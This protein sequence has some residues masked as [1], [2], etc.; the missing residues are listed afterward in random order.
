MQAGNRGSAPGP[1][2]GAKPPFETPHASDSAA[3]AVLHA[4]A[5]PREEAWGADAIRLMLE[6][7]GAY[8][9]WR[10]G[11]GFILARAAAGEAEILTLA[12]H[13]A[14]RRRGLGAGLLA[15]ALAAAAARGAEAMFLEVAAGNA[16]ALALY[17]GLGFARVG[18]RRRYY[19]DGSDAL[20]L[21]RDLT[22]PAD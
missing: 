4:A 9:L 17:E 20:V 16:A 7:P 5:F 11:E 22:G 10:P 14:A 1:A 15:G 13:P 8:G 3:L 21:R 2:K 6:M 19:A 18:L 12:V